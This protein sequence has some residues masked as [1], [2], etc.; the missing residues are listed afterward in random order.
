MAEKIYDLL[1]RLLEDQN[2]VKIKYHI[3]YESEVKNG[4]KI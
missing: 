3:V 2:D 4:K 1:F